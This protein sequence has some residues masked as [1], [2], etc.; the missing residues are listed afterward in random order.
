LAPVI[1]QTVV[2]Q[3]GTTPL[4]MVEH[5]GHTYEWELYS[6]LTVDFAKVPGNCPATSASFTGD[7]IAACVI[8]N[9]LQP[10]IYFFKVTEHDAA[11][12][13]MNF[14]IG[15]IK[16]IPINIKAIITGETPTRCF[17]ICGRYY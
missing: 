2:F 15:M 1:A 9:W 13:V 7:H 12:C 5:S 10:G 17:E 3:G 14:K 16:V 11:H 8:V 4:T 6:D